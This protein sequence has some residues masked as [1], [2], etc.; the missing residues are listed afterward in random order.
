MCVSVFLLNITYLEIRLFYAKNDLKHLSKKQIDFEKEDKV[1]EM[2][3][4]C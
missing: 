1:R 3:W 2:N 4:H